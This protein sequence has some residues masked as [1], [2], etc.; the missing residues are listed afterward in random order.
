M[1]TIIKKKKYNNKIQ[2]MLEPHNQQNGYHNK[3]KTKHTL[4]LRTPLTKL[5]SKDFPFESLFDSISPHQWLLVVS[6]LVLH[7]SSLHLLPN[8]KIAFQGEG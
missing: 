8:Q 7:W 6:E 3:N 2:N 4:H 1:K 5:C